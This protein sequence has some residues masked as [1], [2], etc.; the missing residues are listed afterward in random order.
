MTPDSKVPSSS[1]SPPKTG[2]RFWALIVAAFVT[3]LLTGIYMS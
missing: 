2:F 3:I 1:A